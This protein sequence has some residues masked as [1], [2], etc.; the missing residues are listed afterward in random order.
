MRI[1]TEAIK[2]YGYLQGYKIHI[3]HG[4][5]SCKFPTQ[6]GHWYTELNENKAID[7]A[8]IELRKEGLKDKEDGCFAK[9]YIDYLLYATT[10]I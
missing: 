8:I 10:L 5:R 7:N 9:L 2:H 1:K 4:K 3:S 6:S